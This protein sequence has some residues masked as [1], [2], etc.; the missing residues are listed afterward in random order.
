M[1]LAADYSWR[2]AYNSLVSLS[3]A[4]QNP[5]IGRANASIT[6]KLPGE[7][8]QI[9]AQATNVFNSKDWFASAEFVPGLFGYK[10]PLE[11][12]V[13]RVGFRYKM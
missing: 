8:V 9:Y 3:E 2:A 4:S 10:I 6:Y 11:P 5:A 7:R 1:T 12:R 13:W